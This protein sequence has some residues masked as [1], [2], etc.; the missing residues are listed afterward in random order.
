MTT[1]QSP[2]FL[3]SKKWLLWLALVFLFGLGL[4]IRLYDLTD[5]PL[6]FHAT[7]QLHAAL[8]ARG[9]YYENRLDVPAWQREMAVQ[10]WKSEGLIEPPIM[11]RLSAL[12]YR[13]AGG[14]YLWI[15]RLY[16]IFFWMLGGAALF[17]LA[18]RL[19]GDAG[20]LVGLAYYLFLPFGGIASRSF[21]PDPL[22]TAL[23]VW[24]FWGMARW[25]EARSWRFAV[26][27]GLLTGLAVFAKAVAVFFVGLAWLSLILFGFG[28]RRALRDRQVW[29]IACLSVL[30]Y[31]L[32]H[33]YGVFISGQLQSQFSLRFFPQLWLDPV[34]Y[35]QWK[36]MIASTLI[37]EW[38]LVGLIAVFLIANPSLRAGLLGAW[39]G[40]FL[41]GMA[42]PYHISTHNYY[43]LP[44]IPLVALG[45]AVAADMAFRNIRARLWLAAP[46]IASVLLFAVLVSAWDV[47]VTLKREDWRGEPAFWAA[48]GQEIG[49][50]TPAVGLVEDYGYRLAYW[51]W[52]AVQPWKTSGDIN[53]GAL[54][55]QEYDFERTFKEQTDGKTY[56]IVTNMHE[57]ESQPELE[58]KLL[59]NYPIVA[60]TGNYWIF[61]LRSPRKP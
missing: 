59:N 7:R 11:Q 6:D 22:M 3:K 56:F 44:A 32:F 58:A 61:D 13:L 37:F 20:G 38:F 29:L 57:L 35:L 9:M 55:G 46:V 52:V 33:I 14:E 30:P 47:R 26:L 17:L 28:L 12:T 48:L 15:P 40:Y 45:L 8:M 43:Q 5:P 49:R 39:A 24:C 23:I 1:V 25:L 50:G 21:Q 31:L 2:S 18:R 4:A 16:S 60:Q 27:A 51:G 10:Q 19:A 53:L 34:F 42:L 54:A 36:G 41:Y